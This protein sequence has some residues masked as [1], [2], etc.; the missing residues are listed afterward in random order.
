[1]TNNLL[2]ELLF[3]LIAKDFEKTENI[4]NKLQDSEKDRDKK[5]QDKIRYYHYRF[6]Y[7]GIDSFD[8]LLQATEESE[9]I[10]TKSLGYSF[11]GIDYLKIK[12]YNSSIKYNNLALSISS[13]EETLVT[14]IDSLSLA[15]YDN[16][17]KEE[18]KNIIYSQ[19]ESA[20]KPKIKAQLY[21]SL[22]RYFEKEKDQMN[23]VL[24]LIQANHHAPTDVSIAFLV[25]LNCFTGIKNTPFILVAV[26]EHFTEDGPMAKTVDYL[27]IESII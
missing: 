2:T 27:W 23:R 24:S 22:S 1:M 14:I 20:T 3:A 7:G 5:I 11:L 10:S 21:I 25:I 12:D 17:N 26:K 9:D 15:Y 6:S 4:L 16:N 18:A 8:E 13:D 19:I